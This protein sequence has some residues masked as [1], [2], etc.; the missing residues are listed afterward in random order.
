MTMSIAAA[1]RAVEA[2]HPCMTLYLVRHA[3]SQNN[4][5]DFE[6]KGRGWGQYLRFPDPNLSDLGTK[7]AVLLGNHVKT[8]TDPVSEHLRE[9]KSLGDRFALFSSP[10]RRALKTTWGLAQG[11]GSPPV[12]VIPYAFEHGGCF[13]K[14]PALSELKGLAQLESTPPDSLPALVGPLES[15]T[16]Y[17][18]L[19][20]AQV[21][22][23]DHVS[24]CLELPDVTSIFT[25][26]EPGMESGWWAGQRKGTAIENRKGCF[27]RGTVL[28]K[29]FVNM[30]KT[31]EKEVV[32][33]VSHGD[34]MDCILKALLMPSLEAK[35]QDAACRFVHTNTGITR[36]EIA[37]D[38]TAFLLKHNATPHLDTVEGMLTGGEMIH[39]WHKWDRHHELDIP[40]N[41]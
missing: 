20:A 2:H 30:A 29:R 37:R 40:Q 16:H 32:V 21:T 4:K 41:H 36:V 22:D 14:Y 12:T 39:D 11:L 3:E 25:T 33:L 5:V 31:N 10:M 26:A 19:T 23:P 6:Y 8:S 13:H 15:V 1:K 9:W 35:V 34:L 24:Q 17:P 7:Q 38:G 18:G 28:A 27:E